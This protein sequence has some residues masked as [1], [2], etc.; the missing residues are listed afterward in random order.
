MIPIIIG[1]TLLGTIHAVI[2][3]TINFMITGGFNMTKMYHRD[4]ISFS[5]FSIEHDPPSD[6]FFVRF[7]PDID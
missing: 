5:I 2:P 7:R 6:Q 1:L 4:L 3:Y